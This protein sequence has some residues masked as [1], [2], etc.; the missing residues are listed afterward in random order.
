MTKKEDIHF[1]P[2]QTAEHKTKVFSFIKEIDI[3]CKKYDLAIS[4]TDT[5]GLCINNSETEAYTWNIW[6]NETD[7][8]R[9][10]RLP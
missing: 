1:S 8:A 5:D 6:S 4:A 2:D 9:L 3:L 7:K 10:P